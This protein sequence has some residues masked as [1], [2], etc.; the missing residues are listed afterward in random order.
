MEK[1]SI[2]DVE[3]MAPSDEYV[4]EGA[5]ATSVGDARPLTEALGA[6]G[7]SINHYELEPGESF[8]IT[9]HRHGT[10]EELFY[11]LSGTVTFETVDEDLTVEEDEVLR[12]PPG[13]YQ[14]GTNTGDVP[15]TALALGSPRDYEDETELLVDCPDCGER[16]IHRIE[17]PAEGEYV[18]RCDAC[19]GETFRASA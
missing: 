17:N 18:Y 6:T 4:P 16:T 8:W 7:L 13:T 11:V 12:V 2:A 9:I 1:V 3:P 10:Q 14:L 15:A 19:D 5:V